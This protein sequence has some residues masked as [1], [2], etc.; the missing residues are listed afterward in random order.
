MKSTDKE[1]KKKRKEK[2]KSSKQRKT[3][4]MLNLSKI[5]VKKSEDKEWPLC[6]PYNGLACI[7]DATELKSYDTPFGKKDKFRFLIELNL[8]QEDGKNWVA[9]TQPMTPSTNEK[10]TLYKFCKSIGISPDADD[11]NL[12]QLAGKFINVIVEHVDVEGKVYAN[13]TYTGKSAPDAKFV[14]T[15]TPREEKK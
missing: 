1:K 6:P 11:F 8:P 4:Y 15:Y 10:A 7:V 3:K 2:E 13:V 9:S 14:T 12:G 5:A